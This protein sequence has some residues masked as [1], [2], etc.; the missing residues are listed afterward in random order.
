MLQEKLMSINYQIAMVNNSLAQAK[1]DYIRYKNLYKK[2][3]VPRRAYEKIETEFK[4]LQ[5]KK[6]SLIF[7]KKALIQEIGI[8]KDNV[9]I[10]NEEDMLDAINFGHSWI[11]KLVAFQEE[12]IKE[13]GKAKK[14]SPKTGFPLK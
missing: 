12:I 2:N 7:D 10:V 9:K 4:N 13:V 14:D 5:D 1:R 11:K 6:R 8:A 3:A